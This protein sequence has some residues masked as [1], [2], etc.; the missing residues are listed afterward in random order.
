[1]P[2]N[3]ATEITSAP[4]ETE[5]AEQVS[6]A[7]DDIV[8]RYR[9]GMLTFGAA[10]WGVS[11]ALLA[12]GLDQPEAEGALA[13]YI[14]S[15]VEVDRD[16]KAAEARGHSVLPDK[17]KPGRAVTETGGRAL[18]GRTLRRSASPAAGAWHGGTTEDGRDFGRV[19]GEDPS[20]AWLW[21]TT[22]KEPIWNP[23]HSPAERAHYLQVTYERD[24]KATVRSLVGCTT[25]PRFPIGH[26]RDV[27]CGRYID[28]DKLR[29]DV[30]TL[31]A[32][33]SDHVELGDVAELTIGARASRAKSKN[34][35]DFYTWEDAWNRYSKAVSFAFP[36]RS[37]ELQGYREWIEGQFRAVHTPLRVV[38]LDKAICR[39]VSN[40]A[41]A[42]LDDF[43]LCAKYTTQYLSSFG[44]GE[45]FGDG[46]AW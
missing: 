34:V 17:G 23:A 27:I 28:L 30:H 22:G 9:T 1:M 45:V 4:Q 26:W 21:N 7:C 16:C 13:V 24:A 46:G 8:E 25:R 35:V 43:T 11:K 33:H 31:G 36:M 40:V 19:E 44:T 6:R 2:G 41:L 20:F 10:S 38:A 14:D 15:L 39:E 37:G 29:E 42:R 32:P 3:D 12:G 5:P 18:G